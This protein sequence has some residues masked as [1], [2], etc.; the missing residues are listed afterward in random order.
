MCIGLHHI[1]RTSYQAKAIHYIQWKEG[2]ILRLDLDQVIL[3]QALEQSQMFSMVLPS[4][5][6]SITAGHIWL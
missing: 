1:T 4:V 6:I 3:T 2:H 5:V